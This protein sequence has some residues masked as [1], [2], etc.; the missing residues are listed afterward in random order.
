MIVCKILCLSFKISSIAYL[1][2]S[3]SSRSHLSTNQNQLAFTTKTQNKKQKRIIN[4]NNI[5]TQKQRRSKLWSWWRK[6]KTNLEQAMIKLLLDLHEGRAD[7]SATG[8]EIQVLGSD[9]IELL[10]YAFDWWPL[11]GCDCKVRLWVGF[12]TRKNGF[13]L[14]SRKAERRDGFYRKKRELRWSEFKSERE[15]HGYEQWTL[16]WNQ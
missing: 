12:G 15:V 4:W 2:S 6:K 7:P 11:L 14:L 16:A 1:L 8:S 5:P 13:A 9:R 10:A 3:D